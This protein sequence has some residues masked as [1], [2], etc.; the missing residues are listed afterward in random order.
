MHQNL[1]IGRRAG[2]A[3]TAAIAVAAVLAPVASATA[4]SPQ[5][6]TATVDAQA[7]K[8]T[9]AKYTAYLKQQDGPEAKKVLGTFD[10]MSKAKQTKFVN[11]L[12]DEKVFKAF[13]NSGQ[14][15]ARSGLRSRAEG[16]TVTRYNEDVEFIN[17]TTVARS[18]S[19]RIV[20]WRESVK[21]SVKSKIMGV[22]ITKFTVWVKYRATRQ[23]VDKVYS[24]GSGLKNY[25]AAVAIDEKDARPWVSGGKAHAQTIWKGSMVYR[26]FGVRIDK[27]HS[28]T[29][30]WEGKGRASLK[31]I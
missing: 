27:K 23:R 3:L 21:N 13:L 14:D 24:S 5:P 7:S 1:T 16:R 15:S 2:T 29:G 22:T 19:P 9:P 28:L 12:Q 31:N 17:E 6:G 20:H 4:D 18:G 30:D 25:N 11:Y 10:R 8:L 26:G